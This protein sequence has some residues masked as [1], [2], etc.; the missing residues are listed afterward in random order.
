[1]SEE[2]KNACRMLV[3]DPEE[4]RQQGRPRRISRQ[5]NNMDP[6][7][8]KWEDVDWI[9]LAQDK[10]QWRFIVNVAMKLRIL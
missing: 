2:K 6:K 4:N 1:M 9:H 8:I 7:V 10:D 5:D 3:R